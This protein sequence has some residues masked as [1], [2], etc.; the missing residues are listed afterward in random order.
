[1]SEL[2]PAPREYDAYYL[3]NVELGAFISIYISLL[4]I[5]ETFKV[6][7]LYTSIVGM[8]LST[9]CVFSGLLGRNKE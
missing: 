7:L 4:L 1:M 5:H 6:I 8:N 2:P 9:Y 3:K